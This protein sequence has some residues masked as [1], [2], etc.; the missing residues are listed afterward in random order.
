MVDDWSVEKIVKKFA[1][2]RMGYAHLVLQMERERNRD[3]NINIERLM[4][5]LYEKMPYES[6][7]ERWQLDAL[8][9]DLKRRII[10]QISTTRLKYEDEMLYFAKYCLQNSITVITFN[11]DEFLDKALYQV[12]IAGNDSSVWSPC[13][14]YGFFCPPAE[15]SEDKTKS[16]I[17]LLK[18]HGSLNWRIKMGWARLHVLDAIVH[19]E[20]WNAAWSNKDEYE[21]WDRER[22]EQEPLIVPPLLQKSIYVDHPILKNV[23]EN[24]Y[25]TLNNAEEISFIGYSLP[26]TD[27][28]AAML[29]REATFATHVQKVNL[30]SAVSSLKNI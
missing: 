29:I 17:T 21:L 19:H 26:T 4:S 23:W 18:L 10:N 1:L 5:R 25:L 14:G 28:A 13:R 27:I 2:A 24:A 9:A 30:S 12:G 15:N 3:G 7:E 20:N 22:L 6:D 16:S 11:Y 8:L